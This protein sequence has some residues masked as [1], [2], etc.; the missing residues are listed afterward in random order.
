MANKKPEE[1]QVQPAGQ[2]LSGEEY[3]TVQLFRDSG[4]YAD[5]VFVSVNGESCL[6]R[7]G[8]PVRIKRK[9][10]EVLENSL[11][12]DEQAVQVIQSISN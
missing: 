1:T 4:K 3:V 9:F 8:I 2:N 12:Q 11:R 5:D 7:R 10:A 6:I